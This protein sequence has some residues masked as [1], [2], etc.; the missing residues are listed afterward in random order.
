MVQKPPSPVEPSWYE[1]FRSI[2]NLFRLPLAQ[3]CA[4]V[5]DIGRARDPSAYEEQDYI[6]KKHKTRMGNPLEAVKVIS[7]V[8]C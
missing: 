1:S 2:F 6:F 4:P 8:C 3:D 5:G 7:L